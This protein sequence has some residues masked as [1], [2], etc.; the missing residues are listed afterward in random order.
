[1]VSWTSGGKTACYQDWHPWHGDWTNIL[2]VW[3]KLESL[4]N[5]PLTRGLQSSTIHWLVTYESLR[6]AK[7]V[8]FYL[9]SLFANK[10]FHIRFKSGVWISNAS[11]SIT[12]YMIIIFSYF[13]GYKSGIINTW[14]IF[15][16]PRIC[17]RPINPVVSFGGTCPGSRSICRWGVRFRRTFTILINCP[18]VCW[19]GRKAHN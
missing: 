5:C 13:F 11:I 3:T 7:N 19:H 4:Q 17:T 1:M 14:Y 8:D 15:V 18:S 10:Y 9:L 16:I 2:L 12:D 6:L